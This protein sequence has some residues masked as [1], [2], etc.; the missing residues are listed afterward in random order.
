MESTIIVGAGLTGLLLA[1]ELSRSGIQVTVLERGELARESSWA[2]GG[3]L[4]PL[5]PWRYPEPVTAL[6]SWSQRH[7]GQ[8]VADIQAESG[9]D[10]EYIQ[11]GLLIQGSSEE[12]DEAQAWAQQ[13]DVEMRPVN[14]AEATALE[15]RLGQPAQGLW[16]P[17]VGQVRNPRLLQALI[18]ACTRLG[19]G[20]KENCPVEGVLQRDGRAYGVRTAAA[21]FEADSVVVAGGAWSRE[22]LGQL[23]NKLQVEPVKGQMLLYQAE[24]GLLQRIVLSRGHYLIPR[25]DGHIL[26]GST[27][28]YAGFDKTPTEQARRALQAAAEELIPMLVDYP[29]VKHWAGLRPGSADGIPYI[30]VHPQL[31]SLYVSAGHFRNGVVMAPAS[32]RLLV[33]LML[34]R[35]PILD[36][37]PYVLKA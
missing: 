9:I 6:A 28:E 12:Q 14:P 36:P 31:E 24:A 13:Y 10:P 7:Y 5:Y 15:P 20:F 27:L 2:G 17:R 25:S 33:D 1:R 21:E 30:G 22:I 35:E 18:K 37:L 29:L 3:I 32:A 19:V 23:G 34:G 26:V 8:W 11:S 4:S 16:L